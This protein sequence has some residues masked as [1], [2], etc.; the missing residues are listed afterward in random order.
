MSQVP[1]PAFSLVIPIHNERENLP[2]LAREIEQ[3]LN[4]VTDWECV[5][6]DDGSSDGST[7]ILA[8]LEHHNPRHRLLRLSGKNGQ[9]AALLAGFAFSHGAVLGTMDGDGQNVPADLPRMLARLE[10]AGVDMV[11]G[12]RQV[13]RDTWVRKLSSRLANGWRNTL[14][15]E[16][17]ADVGCAIRVFRRDC[18]RHLPAFRGLHR[19]LPTLIK[20]DGWTLVELPVSHRPREAGTTKYGIH[21]RLWVGLLDTFGVM[22]LQARHARY[23]VIREDSGAPDHGV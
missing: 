17:V 23:T 21:N 18:V 16:S 12:R 3:A 19:F 5:W 22:W 6:V 1:T 20:L 9:S 13:R 11:N 15:R 10:E 2:G 4:G 7:D 8:A 14:T